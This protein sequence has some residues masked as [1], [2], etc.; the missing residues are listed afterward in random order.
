METPLD[1]LS[2]AASLVHADDEK[3]E[4]ALRGEPRLQ[5][6]PV[7]SALTS[8]RTGPPPIS[9]SKRKFTVEPGDDELDCES[10]HASK[11]SRIFAPHLN[12]TANGDCRKDPRERSR[13]PIERAVAPTMSLH[14]SHLYTSLPSLSMEQPLALTKNSLDAGRP[15]GLSPTMTP[16]ERQQVRHDQH[17]QGRTPGRDHGPGPHTHLRRCSERPSEPALGD[18][19]RLRQRPELQPLPLPHRAQRLRGRPGQLPEG[20]E[21]RHHLRPRG[22]GAFP[23]EPGQE[24]QGA[25]TGAQLRVHHGLRGRP[26]RQSPGRHVAPDQGGQGRRVE[27]PRVSLSQGPARQ[28]LCPHGQPQPLPVCGLLKGA[29]PS[30]ATSICMVCLSF[31]QSVLKKWKN[32]KKKS[33]GW[34]EGGMVYSQ[35][36]RRRDFC[37]CTCLVSVPGALR[38]DSSTCVWNLCPL[39]PPS[40][41]LGYQRSLNA[42]QLPDRAWTPRLALS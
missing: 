15:A 38:R 34:G 31:E 26:L 30:N 8:H 33:W 32:E 4:A 12:K 16:V 22:G 3:R 28:P 19:V 42:G 18:H 21:L 14:G 20:P 2:R 10:D 13:S 9:P 41:C 37:S 36:P 6:L 1:V 24:L 29:P 5:T 40:P 39:S 11:M 17:L 35:K 27:Q 23:Q 7:A 25:R